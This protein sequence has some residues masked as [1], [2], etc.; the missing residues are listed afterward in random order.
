MRRNGWFTFT[1]G[2]VRRVVRLALR[3]HMRLV[4]IAVVM[5]LLLASLPATAGT[6]EAR[7][8]Q[9]RSSEAAISFPAQVYQSLS[10]TAA[11]FTGWMASF[12]TSKPSSSNSSYVPVA[13]YISPAPPFIDAPTS[14]SV[15]AA[16]SNSISLSWTAPAGTVDHYVLERSENVNGLFLLVDSVTGATTKNDTT[17]T[18]LHAYL[19]RVRAVSSTG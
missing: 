13:A 9:S 14:L 12:V 10:K 8:Q 7:N 3:N 17:V 18:N 15:T 16:A 5:S 2:S 19:Y 4:A 1:A 6:T 11:S